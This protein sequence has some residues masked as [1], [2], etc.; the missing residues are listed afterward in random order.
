MRGLLSE[1]SFGGEAVMAG[2]FS[3]SLELVRAS[4]DVLN[5]ERK[6]LVFPLL[7]GLCCLLVA[8]S[9]AAPVILSIQAGQGTGQHAQF[10][11]GFYIGLFVFYLVQYTVIFFFNTALVGAAMTHMNGERPT[12]GDGLALAVSKLPQI[13]GYAL[14]AATVGMLLRALQERMGLIGRIVVGMLGLAWTV[15]TFLVVPILAATEDGPIE[16]VKSSAG[17]LKRTWGENIIG[18]AGI[19]IVFTLAYVLLAV[20]FVALFTATSS[21]HSPGLMIAL[22]ALAIAAVIALALVQ[23][24]LQGIYAAALYR[25]VQYGDAGDGFQ[26]GLLEQAFR[27]KR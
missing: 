5:R 1:R 15:A 10:G 12:L 23:S 17:M 25:Y 20:V 6:L 13:F 7:S 21:M 24:A 8:A 14:I 11:S 9:F 3:R 19:H 4:A 16:A 18:N 26:A 2:R 27:P 22:M